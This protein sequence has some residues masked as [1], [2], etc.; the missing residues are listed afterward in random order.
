MI[1]GKFIGEGLYIQELD[2]TYSWK[3][4]EQFSH[5]EFKEFCSF[6]NEKE[7]AKL[8][9]HSEFKDINTSYILNIFNNLCK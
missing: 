7:L 3:E 2:S 4:L 9:N 6:T 1:E 8:L 5:S